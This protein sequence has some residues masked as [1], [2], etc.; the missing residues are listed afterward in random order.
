MHRQR[1]VEAE[2]LADRLDAFDAVFDPARFDGV[3]T[4]V[5]QFS[6]AFFFVRMRVD[7]HLVAH[8]AAQQIPHGLPQRLALD[9]PQCHL[10]AGHSAAA[11]D[12]GHAVAHD[13]HLHFAPQFLDMEGV[14]ADHKG[15]HIVNGGFDDARPAGGFADAVDALVCFDF[16]EEP[17]ARRPAAGFGWGGVHEVSFDRGYFHLQVSLVCDSRIRV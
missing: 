15:S 4:A 3:I 8:L 16:G 13:G 11:D 6:G 10:D 1:P 5:E 17:V 2:V 12:A 7:A 9:V 14:F